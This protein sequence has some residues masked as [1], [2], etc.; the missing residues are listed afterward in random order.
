V[1]PECD[2]VRLMWAEHSASFGEPVILGRH[3]AMTST[4]SFM[5]ICRMASLPLRNLVKHKSRLAS[6]MAVRTGINA[7][8]MQESLLTP[9]N[10]D[11]RDRERSARTLHTVT[12]I[13]L[14]D[15][16]KVDLLG[17]SLGGCVRKPRR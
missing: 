1:Y 3:V 10:V 2:L 11:S 4:I 6:K 16:T 8:S 9:R 12:F 7:R 13:N 17:F 5:P 14:L 15:F